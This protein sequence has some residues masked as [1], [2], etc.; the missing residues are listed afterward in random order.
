MGDVGGSATPATIATAPALCSQGVRVEV[1]GRVVLDG[2]DLDVG[3]GESLAI[4]GP[5]GSGKTTLLHCIAGLRPISSGHIQIGD[6]AISG[7]SEVRRAKIRLDRIGMVFQ[8]GELLSE[9]S[10][11]ENV[12]L[13]MLLR[14]T[15]DH[16]RAME[17]LTAFDLGARAQSYPAEL[18]GGEVQRCAI[19]R[20][21]VGRPTLVLADE[22]TGALDED[23]SHVACDLL[24]ASAREAD[25]GLVVA[26][27][28]PL[29]SAAMDHTVRLRRGKLEVV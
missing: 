11:I 23:M 10:V 22:P 26:T 9:L 24:I 4:M 12:M 2:V 20:A 18:S 15:A 1:G 13:P 21:L 16:S 28:D 29:V 8:F 7:A 3:R 19:A 6:D 27:H 25:A 5:S 14:G 17:I